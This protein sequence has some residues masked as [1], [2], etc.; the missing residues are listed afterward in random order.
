MDKVAFLLQLG[1]MD[2]R[3]ELETIPWDKA[4]PWSMEA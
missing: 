2:P 4:S 1:A 3:I